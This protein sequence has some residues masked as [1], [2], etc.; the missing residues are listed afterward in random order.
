L[1]ARSS[2]N[3]ISRAALPKLPPAVSWRREFWKIRS[4]LRPWVV[5]EQPLPARSARFE[6]V[7]CSTVAPAANICVNGIDSAIPPRRCRHRRM[8][9][10]DPCIGMAGDLDPGSDG[11]HHTGA[12]CLHVIVEHAVIQVNTVQDW[13]PHARGPSLRNAKLGRPPGIAIQRVSDE[14]HWNERVILRGR[15]R[16]E[17]AK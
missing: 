11:G 15:G 10:F 9:T 13:R 17:V 7:A 5:K 3:P 14:G 1:I 4:R 16:A 2:P 8:A 6:E 12:E